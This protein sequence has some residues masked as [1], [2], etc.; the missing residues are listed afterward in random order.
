MFPIRIACTLAVTLLCVS[1]FLGTASS[2]TKEPPAL[3]MMAGDLAPWKTPHGDWQ[4]IAGVELDP[5]NPRKL[6]AKD[7]KILAYMLRPGA[8]LC[9][10]ASAC[11]RSRASSASRNRS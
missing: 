1:A 6:V 3:E 5:K 7:G 9:R 4:E 2:Q 11:A 10:A 8:S